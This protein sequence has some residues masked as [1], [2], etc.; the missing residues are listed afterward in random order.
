LLTG[1][2]GLIEN[3]IKGWIRSHVCASSKEYGRCKKVMLRHLNLE[4]KPAGD[5]AT[6]N[7]ADDPAIVGTE[8]ADKVIMEIAD[9]A[10]RDANDMKAGV[11]TYG[12]YAYFTNDQNYAPRK[13]FRVA[14][15]E[16]FDPESGPSEPPTEK[17]LVQQLMRHNEINSKNSLVAM[18][19]IIQTFQKEL[20][21]Q[22]AA[23]KQLFDQQ[24]EGALLIQDVMNDA[25]RR[26]LDEKKAELEMSVI[27]GV[28]EHLKVVLP[29]VAN[30]IAGKEI[31]PT[32]M[33]RELYMFASLLENLSDEQQTVLRD[34]L[35]PQQ[36]TLLA[37]LLG[38][39]EDKKAKLLGERPQDE[40]PEGEKKTNGTT[41]AV[42]KTVTRKPP[43]RLAALF[44]RR[45]NLVKKDTRFEIR[46]EV[47]RRM[48][49]RAE[50]IKNGLRSAARSIADESKKKD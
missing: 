14:A 17:G 47:T 25:H 50:K 40:E 18:G 39:Y 28:F 16:E 23:N 41:T 27:E 5:V 12:I 13:I 22:R 21:Q 19:Y 49:E 29:I 44:E 32:G 3:Q 37:E 1:S 26:R 38:M 7:L 2:A 9:A 43:N 36:T 45:S 35:N 10:L 34:M 46:D 8:V 20:D 11:Q 31:V 4:R 42:A 24:I 6:I 33:Q 15:D 48:E 30:K